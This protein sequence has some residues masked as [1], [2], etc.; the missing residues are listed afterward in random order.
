MTIPNKTSKYV[1]QYQVAHGTSILTI[2]TSASFEFGEYNEECG[3]WNAPYVER[4]AS[5]GYVYSSRTPTLTDMESEFPTFSHTFLPVTIQFLHWLL[6]T[7]ADGTPTTITVTSLDAGRKYPLTIRNQEDGGSAPQNAQAVDCHC[8]GINV[9]GERDTPLLVS[10]EFAWGTLE[11]I[12][13]N[14]NLTTA[15][16]ASGGC[17][18]TFNGNPLVVWDSDA[19][20]H[21]IVG[22]WRADFASK[23]DWNKVSRNYGAEQSVNTGKN[24]PVKIILSAIFHDNEVWDDYIDRKATTNMTIQFKKYNATNYATFTFTNCRV[25]SI[26]KVGDRYKGHYGTTCALI[27][28][29]VEGTSDWYTDHGGAPTFLTHW[30]TAAL[31]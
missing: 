8:V 6:G 1:W 5:E 4:P 9:K 31:A 26:K 23:Q 13:N 2:A 15:P 3:K 28:E 24:E 10:A 19:D 27:A 30:K 21:S 18:N 22:V 7:T 16:T 25:V 14:V 17:T 20:A 11:D 29:K 12:G